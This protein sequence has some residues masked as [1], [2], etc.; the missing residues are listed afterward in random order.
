MRSY[1]A[2]VKA[3]ITNQVDRYVMEHNFV[4]GLGLGSARDRLSRLGIG[5]WIDFL[6]LNPSLLK[7]VLFLLK[8]NID[9]VF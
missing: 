3:F 5:P 7:M 6:G 9:N 2:Y 1:V 4:K 8:G